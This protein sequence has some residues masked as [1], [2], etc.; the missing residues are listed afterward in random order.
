MRACER[1]LNQENLMKDINCDASTYKLIT[2]I[3]SGMSLMPFQT[4]SRIEAGNGR[5]APRN[6][7]GRRMGGFGNRS[8]GPSPPP[9]GGGG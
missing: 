7:Q 9:M 8:S 2:F 6:P 1:L 3:F 4:E 5:A